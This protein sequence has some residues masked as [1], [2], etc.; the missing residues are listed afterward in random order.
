VSKFLRPDIPV[1]RGKKRN[2]KQPAAASAGSEDATRVETNELAEAGGAVLKA[3]R[4]RDRQLNSK[5]T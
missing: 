1:G 5:H 3:L 2:T 4:F